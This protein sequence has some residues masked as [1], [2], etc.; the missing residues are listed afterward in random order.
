M[1]T[2]AV[3]RLGLL[4]LLL[5]LVTSAVPMLS[6]I[7]GAGAITLAYAGA[8]PAV[9][10]AWTSANV[11]SASIYAVSGVGAPLVIFQAL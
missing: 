6:H 9:S 3:S 5:V 2:R 7:W 10:A 11:V 4:V 8:P 1:R